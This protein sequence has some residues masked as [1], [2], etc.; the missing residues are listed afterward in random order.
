MTA[1]AWAA[2]ATVYVVWGSTYLAIMVAIRT[3]PPFLMSSA[4]FLVAGG[5]LYAF[6]LRRGAARPSV[7]H[8][9]SAAV[10]GGALLV[11]GNGGVAWS[12]QRIDSGV[13]ALLIATMPLWIALFDRVFAGRRLSRSRL[14]G[15]FVGL[16]GVVLLVGP[17]GSTGVDAVGALACLVAAVSWAGG[18]VYARGAALPRDLLLGSSMQMLSA[19]V[20]LAAAGLGS[21]EAG[22]VQPVSAASLG[23][24]AYL[25]VVGSIV[26][27]SAYVW[28]LKSAPISIVSTYAFVNPAIAV[29]L[30][31]VFLG[32]P[33]G[34][35]TL[36]ASA[37]IIV[38]VVL[39]VTG[40]E[41][42]AP[43][44]VRAPEPLP[45]PLRQAA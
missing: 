17:V 38:S 34:L 11:V 25:V 7:R 23:A 15:L 26:T 3:L 28:L 24:V 30:G 13:A 2:L 4:R 16:G 10:A 41:G 14:L 36:A 33:L 35:R 18:S 5:I 12:E 44:P 8:W 19:G 21:G 22:Q 43:A 39:I 37:A 9:R 45:E 29:A 1:R 6:A 32:E 20:L 42:R 40:R 27:Y 31:A